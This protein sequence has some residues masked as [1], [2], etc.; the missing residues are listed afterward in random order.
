[1]FYCIR[2]TYQPRRASSSGEIGKHPKYEPGGGALQIE[3]VTVPIYDQFIND[4]L[5]DWACVVL[6]VQQILTD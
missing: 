5:S 1:M 2:F 4:R 3:A 6:S